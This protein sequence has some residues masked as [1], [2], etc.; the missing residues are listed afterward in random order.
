MDLSYTLSR[1]RAVAEAA[2]EAS[3]IAQAALSEVE[4][5]EKDAASAA[6]SAL[7]RVRRAYETLLEIDFLTG[8]RRSRRKIRR[9]KPEGTR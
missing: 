9:R 1:I 5:S 7:S 4:R 2:E 6:I 8:A 3:A